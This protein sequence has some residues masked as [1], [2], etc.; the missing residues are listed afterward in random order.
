[1]R[2]GVGNTAGKALRNRRSACSFLSARN[3]D[4]FIDGRPLSRHRAIEK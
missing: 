3:S 1:L 2:T 4:I